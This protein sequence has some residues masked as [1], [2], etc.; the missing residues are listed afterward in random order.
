MTSMNYSNNLGTHNRYNNTSAR[1][2][3]RYWKKSSLAVQA[4]WNIFCNHC[5]AVLVTEPYCSG[6]LTSYDLNDGSFQLRG[7]PIVDR[8]R[9]EPCLWGRLKRV[10]RALLGSLSQGI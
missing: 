4:I 5:T 7:S 1:I 10:L 3:N 6:W 9:C 8:A 2:Y